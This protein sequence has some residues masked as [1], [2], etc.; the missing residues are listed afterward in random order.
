MKK[1]QFKAIIT[2]TMIIINLIPLKEHM[3]NIH[4]KKLM[5]HNLW[6]T[7]RYSYEIL[8]EHTKQSFHLTKA[9]SIR[10]KGLDVFI[11]LQPI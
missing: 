2:V 1:F 4:L 11:F 9:D 3:L 10:P 6:L 5:S 7:L 8:I